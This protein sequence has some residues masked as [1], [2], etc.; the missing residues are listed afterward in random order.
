MNERGERIHRQVWDLLPWYVNGTLEPAERRQVE[1]HLAGCRTCRE[2]A[3]VSRGLATLVR[4]AGEVAPSPHP[5]QLQRLL[6]RLD[7]GAAPAGP[8]R[9]GAAG[10]LP[11]RVPSRNGLPSEEPYWQLSSPGAERG[12]RGPA[13]LRWLAAAQAAALAALLALLLVRPAAPPPEVFRTLSDA[14]PPASPQAAGTAR[15][16]LLFAPETPERDIRALLAQVEG[17]IA[18][19]PS[20]L[21]VY[22]VQVPAGAV[23]DPLPVVLAYL[24]SHPAVRFAEPAADVPA[25]EAR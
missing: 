18:G 6:A 10:A 13:W 24:R 12:G 7:D 23:A 20:P 4:E 19:G 14:P 21:G 1:E 17:Q 9:R 2:E 11:Q 15:I 25:Q 16:R 5:V 22:T 3:E 8:G